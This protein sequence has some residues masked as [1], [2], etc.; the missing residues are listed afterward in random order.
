MN[1]G[2]SSEAPRIIKQNFD[3]YVSMARD[4]RLEIAKP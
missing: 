2:Y 1:V 3:K 4:L